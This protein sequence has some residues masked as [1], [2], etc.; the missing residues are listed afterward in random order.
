MHS[1][2]AP[3]GAASESAKMEAR[4]IDWGILSGHMTNTYIYMN[5]SLQSFWVKCILKQV[6]TY[7]CNTI[8]ANG[9]TREFTA[10]PNIFTRSGRLGISGVR[11]SD[12]C[13]QRCL[14]Q[15]N[16]ACVGYEWWDP[17]PPVGSGNR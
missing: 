16:D 7:N 2:N 3:R 17:S 1:K 10:R 12:I 9:C 6:F 15:A 14:S 8:L 11:S 13:K 5:V 4:T